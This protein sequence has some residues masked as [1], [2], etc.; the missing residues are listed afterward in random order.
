[1]IG[2]KRKR[3]G[4]VNQEVKSVGSKSWMPSFVEDEQDVFSQR[5]DYSCCVNFAKCTKDELLWYEHYR[6][7][8]S[9]TAPIPANADCSI[10]HKGKFK[11]LPFP[12]VPLEDKTVKPPYHTCCV[13]AVGPMGV[14]SL[15][16]AVGGYVFSDMGETKSKA[17]YLYA[18]HDQYTSMLEKFLLQALVQGFRVYV[19]IC[20]N[21]P[22]LVGAEAQALASDFKV[23]IR[24]ISPYTP[25]EGGNH[26][27][28]V[29]DITRLS[30]CQM[31]TAKWM[32]DFMWG[33]S[34]LYAPAVYDTIVHSAIGMSPYQKRTGHKPDLDALGI[35]PWGSPVV[36]G[37][38][39]EDR[40]HGDENAVIKHGEIA[41]DGFF[42]GHDGISFLIY[43]PV[44]ISVHKVSRR[45]VK[46]LL[47]IFMS[48]NPSIGNLQNGV[49]TAKDDVSADIQVMPSVGAERHGLR[50]NT[51][52]LKRNATLER[53]IQSQSAGYPV[54]DDPRGMIGVRVKK[55]F[56]DNMYYGTVV[57]YRKPWYKVLYDDNDEEELTLKEIR[58]VMTLEVD[59]KLRD[60]FLKRMDDE[61]NKAGS[62]LASTF[63][64][65]FGHAHCKRFANKEKWDHVLDA[66]GL[67]TSVGTQLKPTRDNQKADD[68]WVMIT[69]AV[70]SASA[71]EAARLKELPLP[72][73]FFKALTLEDWRNWVV[74]ARKE[75]R[76]WKEDDVYEDTDWEKMVKEAP[77]LKFIEVWTRKY[78][79][80]D[81][82]ETVLDKYKL[83]C[84]AGGHWINHLYSMFDVYAPSASGESTRLA[85]ALA[86]ESGFEIRT[87]DVSQAYTKADEKRTIY[88]LKPTFADI[89]EKPWDELEKLRS[90]LLKLSDKELRALGNSEKNK[91]TSVWRHKKAIYGVPSAG[92]DWEEECVATMASLQMKPCVYDPSFFHKGGDQWCIAIKKTDDVL[93]F[94]R[95]MDEFERKFSEKYKCTIH[96]KPTSFYGMHI[97]RGDD[98]S[99]ELTQPKLIDK[100]AR[101]YEQYL[102]D[103]HDQVIPMVASAEPGIPTDAEIESARKLPYRNLVGGLNYLA[104]NTMPEISFACNL[105]ARRNKGWSQAWFDVAVKVLKYCMCNRDKGVKY[106]KGKD[107]FGVNQ[108][109]SFGDT[110]LANDVESRKS[111]GGSI[112]S[113][114]RGP[115]SFRARL[116]PV[117]HVSTTAA[118]LHQAC[119]TAL[120]AVA[121]RN[122]LHEI[123]VLQT[124]PTMVYCDNQPAVR[125]AHN[126]GAMSEK[127]K[128]LDIRIFKIKQLIESKQIRLQYIKTQRNLSDIF[129]K[130]LPAQQ[131]V[132][133]RDQ[134]KGYSD[135][136]LN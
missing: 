34:F 15:Y 35:F 47:S 61:N 109:Y 3:A 123:G 22:S 55:K 33:A 56:G 53:K 78:M 119:K 37:L 10:C 83:R 36:Y 71:I 2:T 45:K 132:F 39:K 18:S 73:N 82:G 50:L 110:D 86:V 134:L 114:N 1:M 26:E 44:D 14:Q 131:F 127:T 133:L 8:H 104:I 69:N 43:N 42:C 23:L 122:L 11:R 72:F 125:I 66:C 94:G 54:E 136:V 29:G 4:L 64:K 126:Q 12:R 59:K 13:D 27:K 84:A 75:M 21:H 48:P 17:T 58:S 31:L 46:F 95:G 121:L 68:V 79:T 97:K 62:L 65:H 51:A 93:Y 6:T 92:K 116:L 106:S 9:H 40:R 49:L 91:P 128:H 30:R 113:M 38:R 19:I 5:Y 67:L 118:E 130:N 77:L 135:L 99:Y 105:L 7:S 112:V 28:S 87:L 108:I 80:N 129:T 88:S 100:M 107:P 76:G 32:P 41:T 89:C 57:G 103:V 124:N 96:R 90:E 52:R 24:P 70:Q 115:I 25:Q 63:V 81:I 20:D 85:I 120:D 117:V 101:E 102:V 74:C 16:G 98:G 111:M 60:H